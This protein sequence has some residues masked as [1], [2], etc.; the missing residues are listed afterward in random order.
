MEISISDPVFG[1]RTPVCRA[2]GGRLTFSESMGS[3]FMSLF[4]VPAIDWRI[5]TEVPI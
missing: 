4:D 2:D 3:R 5:F 1:I